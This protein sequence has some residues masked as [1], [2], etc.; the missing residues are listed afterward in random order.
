MRDYAVQKLALFT[1]RKIVIS[2]LFINPCKIWHVD[3]FSLLFIPLEH[4]Y[5]SLKYYPIH[6]KFE[7]G[8]SEYL[9]NLWHSSKIS[10]L[11][12]NAFDSKSNVIYKINSNNL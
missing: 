8:A 6:S 12:Q 3:W 9:L 11:L 5:A 2:V 1:H 10:I 4:S 7:F